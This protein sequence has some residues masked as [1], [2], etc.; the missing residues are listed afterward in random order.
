MTREEVAEVITFCKKND[1]SYK[2]RLAE[3]GIPAWKFYDSKSRYALEQESS[4][5]KGEFL[6]L[7]DG[8]SSVPMPS[9]A[10]MSGRKAKGRKEASASQM[11]SIELRTPNCT[12]M[13]IQGEIGPELYPK[14][15]QG[16][17]R[18]NKDLH[19]NGKPVEDNN[20]YIRS[21]IPRRKTVDDKWVCKY[22][23]KWGRGNSIRMT[24]SDTSLRPYAFWFIP[25]N[26]H[27]YSQ[28]CINDSTN[29][30]SISPIISQ[31]FA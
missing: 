19:R 13:R 31:K 16:V 25:K 29:L 22:R 26:Y 2:A 20:R 18:S 21:T 12:M 5:A 9:F 3:L 11:L 8:G 14:Y 4:E 1:I 30:S 24:S 6:Q 28:I 10:A 7:Y 23:Q 27:L 15:N 17:Q